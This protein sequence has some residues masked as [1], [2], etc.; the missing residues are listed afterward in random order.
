MWEA[1]F[2]EEAGGGGFGGMGGGSGG[3]GGGKDYSNK[4]SQAVSGGTSSVGGFNGSG[5][6]VNVGSA[7]AGASVSSGVGIALAVALALAVGIV[8]WKKL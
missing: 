7:S 5:W 1:L 3:S 2:S 8:A 4:T 6:T